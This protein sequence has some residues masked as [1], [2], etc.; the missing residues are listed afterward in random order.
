MI[1]YE[2]LLADARDVLHLDIN[3]HATFAFV[4]RNMMRQ[5]AND[6]IS[7]KIGWMIRPDAQKLR[8]LKASP[9]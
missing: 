2:L 5:Q 7:T 6:E 1:A 3:D 8:N 9:T 4:E